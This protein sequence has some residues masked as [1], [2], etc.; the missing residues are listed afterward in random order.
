MRSQFSAFFGPRI[1]ISFK[2]AKPE[3]MGSSS[4]GMSSPVS[5]LSNLD[6]VPFCVLC[7][8]TSNVL[9]RSSDRC[10]FAFGG[11][12]LSSRGLCRRR[13]F[14]Y[15]A[16]EICAAVFV[17]NMSTDGATEC[18]YNQRQARTRI[19]CELCLLA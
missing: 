3:K 9:S 4:D 11:L 12:A 14:L 7:E 18:A 8:W 17:E 2:L 1:G 15:E 19:F 5:S 10:L 16:D 6:C 13:G